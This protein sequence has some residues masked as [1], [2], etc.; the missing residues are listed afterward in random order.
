MF[1]MRRAGG[2]PNFG[3]TPT[4][5]Q[6]IVNV[7][8]NYGLAGMSKMQGGA[9]NLYDTVLYTGSTTNRVNY[10][11]FTN[12]NNK[13]LNFTNWNGQYNAGQSLSMTTL[14]IM[15]MILTGTNLASDGTTIDTVNPVGT[16][17]WA[18]TLA[19]A[20][21]TLVIG[22]ATIFEDFQLIE[23]YPTANP[24][25]NGVSVSP[26]ADGPVFSIGRTMI[27]LPTMPVLL[28][29]IKVEFIISAPPTQAAVPANAAIMV[30][31]GRQGSGFAARGTF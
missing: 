17:E 4:P 19:F 25:N 18:T 23:L 14:N 10:S 29:N 13:S 6:K 1:P 27:E 22:G 8:D 7:A 3:K 9:V 31:L 20:T 16:D 28:P 15:P 26:V 30:T 5:Q 2:N 11:F 12:W 21:A 24:N